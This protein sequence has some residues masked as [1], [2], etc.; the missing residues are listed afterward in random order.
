MSRP[1]KK[2]DLERKKRYEKTAWICQPCAKHRGYRH[3]LPGEGHVANQIGV[4][5]Y[6]GARVFVMD[7]DDLISPWTRP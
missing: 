6:C 1:P 4:C 3:P 5:D 7:M 2:E